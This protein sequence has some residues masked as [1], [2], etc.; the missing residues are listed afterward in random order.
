MFEHSCASPRGSC[1]WAGAEL[2]F[3]L[4]EQTSWKA[5]Q[6]KGILTGTPLTWAA[7]ADVTFRCLYRWDK[8]IRAPYRLLPGGTG[9]G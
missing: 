5:H 2:W 9:M 6:M 4:L 7:W 1:S 3:V 8:A